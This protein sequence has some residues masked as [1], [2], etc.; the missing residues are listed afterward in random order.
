MPAKM[1]TYLKFV[2]KCWWLVFP[3]LLVLVVAM[4]IFLLGYNNVGWFIAWV[5]TVAV[6]LGNLT[7]IVFFH[8]R[9]QRPHFS[10]F[11]RL[12]RVLWFERD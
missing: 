6:Q 12:V 3:T 4:L 7:Y 10:W 11:Q 8:S 5:G 2:D 9:K 1:E